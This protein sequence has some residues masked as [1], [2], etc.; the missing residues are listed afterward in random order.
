MNNNIAIALVVWKQIEANTHRSADGVDKIIGYF[1]SIVG[2]YDGVGG[3]AIRV[4][5]A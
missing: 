5:I 3:Q 4:N 1:E 2:A